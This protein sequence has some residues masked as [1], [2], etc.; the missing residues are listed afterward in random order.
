VSAVVPR[1]R[2]AH[3]VVLFVVLF[4]V[5]LLSSSIATFLRRAAV[6]ASVALHRDRA[7]E[8]EALARGGVRLAQALLLEDLRLDAGAQPPDTLR[9]AW[10]RVAGLDLVADPD[11]S[12]RLEIEDAAARLNLNALAGAGRPAAGGGGPG[13]GDGGGRPGGRDT[14]ADEAD[15]LFLLHF[16]ERVVEQMPG[17]PEEKRYDLAALVENLID[18]VDAD[19]V[20]QSGGPEDELYQK[21]VPPYRAANRPLLSVDELRGVEGFD[22]RLVEALRPYVSVF[23]LT[24]GGGVNLNTAPDWVLVQLQRGTDVS[25]MRPI[26]EEDV[27]RVLEARAEG[28]L[29]SQAAQG[30]ECVA[31]TE[32][33]EGE[34]LAPPATDRSAVFRVRAVARVVDV[35][36]SIETWIDRRTPSEPVRLS[37]RVR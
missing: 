33:F 17:R 12:L 27:R 30:E 24:G 36:R 15:R 9:D 35:E 3:G 6:D 11:V 7:L 16:L 8:A 22:G 19:E 32:L 13:A 21:R 25:G 4:F 31:V 2:R 20:R 14:G 18:W 1:G 10:A 23:P 34:S 28:I 26:E 5:L 37:W 29:C